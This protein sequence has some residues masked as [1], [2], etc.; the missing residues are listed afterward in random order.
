M[1]LPTRR[2]VERD[3][4]RLAVSGWR[5]AV[6]EETKPF[7]TLCSKKPILLGFDPLESMRSGAE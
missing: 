1:M 3:E 2:F 5:L 4:E 6:G 7:V